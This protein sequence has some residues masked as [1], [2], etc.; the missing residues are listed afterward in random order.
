MGIA[1]DVKKLGEDIIASYD[2]RVK[3]IGQLVKD[4]HQM[5]K[6]FHTEHEE[7]A[8]ELKAGLAKG[9]ADRLRDHKMLMASIQ[10]F[11]SNVA[12]E[13]DAMIKRF[14]TEHKAMANALA[15][16][17][18]KGETD[19]LRAYKAMMADIRRGIKQIET[20][21][22]KKL[23]EFSDAH[24]EMSEELK[25]ELAK[26]VAGVVRET[27][28]LLGEYADESEKMAA[29]WQALSTTMAR[30][31]GGRSVVSAGAEVA[32]V[33]KTT[34][35]RRKGKGKKRGRKKGKGKKKG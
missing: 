4:T 33:K 5:L 26:Y 24:A 8:D 32:T 12:K 20:Y 14:Y 11:V 17:L 28:Q 10:K 25:K 7:M 15:E 3:A 29:N 35:K 6:G 16:D 34:A 22:K 13:V 23:A 19:R 2:M 18:E 1:T 31:R 9:E 30:K 27:K 21:V